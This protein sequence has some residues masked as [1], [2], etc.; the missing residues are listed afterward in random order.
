MEVQPIN[1]LLF[2]LIYNTTAETKKAYPLQICFTSHI[3]KKYRLI[4]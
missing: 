4:R 1:S 2:K 3:S